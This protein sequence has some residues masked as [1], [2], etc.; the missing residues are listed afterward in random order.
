LY[1]EE[2]SIVWSVLNVVGTIAFAL[3][4]SIV[5]MEE[6]YDWLGVYV[7]GF[8][9]AF[10]GGMI[11]NLIVGLPVAQIWHQP[12]LFLTAA[13]TITAVLI[14]PYGFVHRFRRIVSFFDAIGLAA[15]AVEGAMYAYRAHST[16]V[17]TV[18]A[19]LMT[20]IG[21]GLI[22]DLLASR[23]PLVFQ[24]EIY[25]IWAMLAGAAV[26]LGLIRAAWEEYLLFALV[27]TLRILS[28]RWNWHLP[29]TGPPEETTRSFGA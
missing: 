6:R 7:L 13:L 2:C 29:R 8:V 28:V 27:A 22:R 15:F 16:F 14:L 5:A 10:G 23:K 17:T 19:A 25:A 3:S 24:T 4:G 11:R 1:K 21:G 26:G 18:V 9:A 12:V 20:G